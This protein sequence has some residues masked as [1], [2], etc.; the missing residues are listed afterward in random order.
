MDFHGR[1]S[2]WSLLIGQTIALLYLIFVVPA[3]IITF[4]GQICNAALP[5]TPTTKCN[6]SSY[7][8][9][10][11]KFESNLNRVF[12]SLL[13]GTKQSGF[14]I[15]VYG[16][17]PDK[18]YGRLQC[19]EDLT[20]DQCYTCSQYAMTTIQQNCGNAIGGSI[21]PFH[22]FLRYESYDFIGQ[23]D[24]DLGSI[25]AE[26]FRGD[27]GIFIP[28]DFHSSA[29]NLLNK[30]AGEA[31]PKTTRSAL[32]TALDSFSQTIYGLAQCTR[33]L[34][35][36]DCTQCLSYSINKIFK[37]YPGYAG[38]QYWSQSCIVRYEI[39]PFF[40]STAL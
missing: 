15:S 12:D 27:T 24:T 37:S 39:Y 13:Q 34:S 3:F 2:A 30:L 26:D 29:Q 23:L 28:T 9:A 7:Y 14:N 31:A 10:G 17:S 36:D 33:D 35:T 40:N 22:C 32:G 16:E 5:E 38:V 21:W 25:Y 19:R 20:V 4:H 6:S 8:K 11:S 18:V 1:D